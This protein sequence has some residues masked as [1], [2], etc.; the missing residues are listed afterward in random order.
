ML[1]DLAKDH[2]TVVATLKA[3]VK[4]SEDAG[5]VSTAD[6]CTTRLTAHE[7]HLWMIKAS[8]QG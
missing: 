3:A 8:L 2:A 5:D 4:A 7:K 6:L 1:K